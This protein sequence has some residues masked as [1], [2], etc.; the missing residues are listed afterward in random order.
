M[1]KETKPLTLAYWGFRSWGAPSRMLLHFVDANFDD[2]AY[3]KPRELVWKEKKFN[4]GFDFP[5]L[6]YLIDGDFKL[7]QSLS[8]L[9][10]LGRKYGLAGS[11]PQEAAEL[12]MFVDVL[13]DWR[14]P[15]YGKCILARCDDSFLR[16]P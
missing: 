2:V 3:D 9:R 11:T 1:A 13:N 14:T 8:I 4:L 5:N 10:Y 12:D 15:M 6:P 16:V 7:T